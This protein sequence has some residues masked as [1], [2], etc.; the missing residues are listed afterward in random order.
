M[1][2][3]LLLSYIIIKIG[4]LIDIYFKLQENQHGFTRRGVNAVN[5]GVNAVTTVVDAGGRG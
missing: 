3:V 1:Y 4:I 5:G 2:L